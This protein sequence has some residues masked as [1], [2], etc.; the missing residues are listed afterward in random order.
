MMY[1]KPVVDNAVLHA[2]YQFGKHVLDQQ[3]LFAASTKKDMT[4]D[5]DQHQD[6]IAWMIQGLN[7]MP[8]WKRD[9]HDQTH[10]YYAQSDYKTYR[11][12]W[13]STA[14]HE[15]P[16][17]AWY[18]YSVDEHATNACVAMYTRDQRHALKM[19]TEIDQSV[20]MG[21][22]HHWMDQIMLAH[23][24]SA[25]YTNEQLFDW[26]ESFTQETPWRQYEPFSEVVEDLQSELHRRFPQL[27]NF[28]CLG[29]ST[30]HEKLK[31]LLNGVQILRNP[32]VDALD[33]YGSSNT[34][35]G[36]HSQ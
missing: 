23:Q 35:D 9:A 14:T 15:N 6:A 22:L 34:I 11:Y 5:D 33:V 13:K 19:Y 27:K 12:Y 17:Y 25:E 20:W 26:I 16:F 3:H 8:Y 30:E 2:W 1:V 7:Y 21:M 29:V 31:M 24:S 10:E 32:K 4:F 28:Q 18:Q 36:L